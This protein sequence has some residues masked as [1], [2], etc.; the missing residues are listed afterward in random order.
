[1]T[2][3]ENM[4][5]GTIVNKM[6]SLKAQ[7]AKIKEQYNALATELQKRALTEIDEHNIKFVQYKGKQGVASVTLS[8][9]L[10]LICASEI[11]RLIGEPIFG[12]QFVTEAKTTYK[13]RRVAEKALKAIFLEDYDFSLSIS[14]VYDSL[15]ADEKQR[16]LLDKKLKGE[17]EKDLSVLQ[18]VFGAGNYDVELF[19]IY[20]IK[21]AEAVRVIFGDDEDKLK[22]IRECL[23]VKESLKVS[24][25]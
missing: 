10:E 16:T 12:E 9:T 4:R 15:G 22:K 3:V 23:Y 6:I 14:D 18:S 24:V 20:K 21:N 8:G 2:D 19:C 25:S 5:D 17:Y 1:M 11:K 7:E 13:P